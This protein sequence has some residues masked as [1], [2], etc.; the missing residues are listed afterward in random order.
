MN[1]LLGRWRRI[2]DF[3]S[4]TNLPPLSGESGDE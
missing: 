3:M 4:A 2:E 1:E